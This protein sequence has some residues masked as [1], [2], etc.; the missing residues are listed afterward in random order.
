[1]L[2]RPGPRP[3][4][5]TALVGGGFS[6]IIETWQFFFGLGYSDID[7][8]I[9]NTLGAFIGAV[10]AKLCGPRFH[11]LCAGVAAVATVAFISLVIVS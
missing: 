4:L 2:Y 1:M 5:A 6:L 7:D 8:L 10:L 11:P 9:L 3:L